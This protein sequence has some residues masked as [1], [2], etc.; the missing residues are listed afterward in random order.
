MKSIAGCDLIRQSHSWSIELKKL[1]LSV[2]LF[3][4]L[5][6]CSPNIKLPG[7]PVT[8][9]RIT[10][11]AIVM[12]DGVQLPLH[13]W[14]HSRGTEAIILALHGFNDYGTFIN[15]AA[16]YFGNWGVKVYSY[17]H[18]GF[19]KSPHR[20]FWPG[21]DALVRDLVTTA[22]LLKDSYPGVPMYLLGHSM[23]GAVILSA[24]KVE[25]FPELEG[26]I[27]AAPAV[28]GRKTMPF[29]QKLLLEIGVRILP[30]LKLSG[31]GLGVKP[32]DNIEMLKALGRDP[33]II[34]DTRI[35]TL[36]GLVNLMDTALEGSTLLDA[37]V[38][39]L[40]G[41][42]DQIIRK[43]STDFLL[44][45]LPT[46]TT[47]RQTK[48]YYEDGYHMLLRDLNSIKVWGDILNWLGIETSDD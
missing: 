38:L 37:N 11:T 39:I 30:W 42:N 10:K 31:R 34:K 5:S 1:L 8:T 28:W 22:K 4:A 46:S 36:W 21:V 33:L 20:G 43:K 45:R 35:D 16:N 6:A 7:V 3:S 44:S 19:G 15:S 17:D 13:T 14:S 9:A 47:L 48:I 27:L 18:R 29:Y 41:K 25:N 23:G 24:L 12:P 40:L 32:S 26:V 2:I